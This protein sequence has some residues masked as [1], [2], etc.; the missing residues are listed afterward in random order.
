MSEELLKALM[1]LFGITTILDGQTSKSIL[2]VKEFLSQQINADDVQKYLSIFEEAS[3]QKINTVN[4]PKEGEKLTP[5]KVS[6]LMLKYCY[7]INKELTQ[8]QKVIIILRMLELIT[9]NDI[10]TQQEQE[11]LDTAASVFNLHP[12]DFKNLQ[13]FVEFT[14][15][16]E[17]IT[18]KV[19]ESVVIYS[20][21]DLII[22]NNKYFSSLQGII[23][24]LRIP[25][26]EMYLVK[27][28][29]FQDYYLNGL[30]LNNNQ[31]Y[32]FPTGSAI[33]GNRLESIY[34]SDVVS[35]FRVNNIEEEISFIAKDVYF[36]FKNSTAG[37]RNININENGGKLIGIMGASGS[38]KS[39]LLEILNGTIPTKQGDIIINGVNI[40]KHTFQG[41]IGYVPQE[42]MLIEE[43]SVRENLYYAAKLCLGNLTE[44]EINVLIRQTL[45][46][47]GLLEVENM[48]VGTLLQRIIS[49]GQRKR[50]NIG[51]EL[52]R[53]P[54]ILFVDEP[55]SGL[56]S[57][58]SENIMD[59]LKE[60]SLKG[61]LIFA[62]IH[63]P[64][65]NI[66]KMLDKLYI[67]DI[68]GYPIY[69]GNPT[70]SLLYF[71]KLSKQVNSNIAACYE[72]GNVNAELIFDIVE[73]K[74]VNEYGR[75]T[76][77]RKTTPYQWHSLF[78]QNI[79][80]PKIKEPKV[81]VNKPLILPNWLKQIQIFF[82]RDFLSKVYDKQYLLVSFGQAPLLAFLLS[83][84][85]RYYPLEDKSYIFADNE[86]LPVYIFISIIVAIFMGLVI[87]AEEILKDRKILRR[88]QFL[89]LNW[90]SYLLSKV[91]ILFFISSIQTFFLVIVGNLMLGIE[92]SLSGKYFL[93]L[94]SSSCFA[95]LLGLNISS[96]FSSAV[97]TYVF[98]PLLLVPQLVLGG[99]VVQFN[100]VNPQMLISDKSH[101]P[102]FG[103]LMVS[104]W[105]FESLMVAQFKD[106]SYNKMLY[107]YDKKIVENQINLSF[108]F[109]IIE[110]HIINKTNEPFIKETLANFT[111]FEIKNIKDAPFILSVLKKDA[112]FTQNSN[113]KAKDDY[114]YDFIKNK[115]SKESLDL[116]Q[117]STHNEAVASLV[118]NTD[119][120]PKVVEFNN[121]LDI[122]TQPIY[123]DGD[124]VFSHFFAPNKS[125]FGI[126][127][128]TLYFNVMMIWAMTLFLF[129]L[130]YLDLPRR[131]KILRK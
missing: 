55:T 124:G 6:S 72:C 18:P 7:Q 94:F 57:R 35:Q 64:S 103:E 3:N 89:N 19:P 56:S 28:L 8:Q 102:F 63:Q 130:L 1:Q 99:I 110:N 125:I 93:V 48:R 40:K 51:L 123:R 73:T 54:S 81:H 128:D 69:Y 39:T 77:K 25:T 108:S 30:L 100:K 12:S 31:T 114:I 42:D 87:S 107:D 67:L 20:N 117:K 60:L 79:E 10:I 82:K 49:G 4:T 38:G 101:I 22:P 104:R 45:V 71:K 11:Y 43:L 5:M 62:V 105:A 65:S 14:E 111:K 116:L 119:I 131:L 44:N 112:V 80:I 85:N 61:K 53:S 21:I 88:E 83:Y 36:G 26:I 50:L 98:I 90:S 84:V 58:D 74:V 127:I 34:Y 29:G 76:E 13:N 78:Q 33:R 68:G 27:Y 41:L 32:L 118:R 109:P 113:Q 97:T 70:E 92:W 96:A 129:F 46:N 115:K 24:I 2:V 121:H 37:L 120:S 23:C 47:L 15:F 52:L 66:F 126:K 91:L 9:V 16:S 86:N 59:L 17:N 106:N 75:F 95:N 122:K